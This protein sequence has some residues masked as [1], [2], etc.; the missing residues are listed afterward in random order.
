MVLLVLC[1][2]NLGHFSQ[3]SYFVDE[4]RSAFI[5]FASM[6][7]SSNSKVLSSLLTALRPVARLLMKA[8]IGYREF[9]EIAKCA[10]VDVAT[11]DYGLRGRPTNIS[12]VAVMT[13]L[14]RK[15][16]KRLR[17]KISSGI[18]AE[19]LRVI[20]PAEILERWHSDQEYLDS[21]GRP[22][23]LSFDGQPP[24]F[25]EL[26][27]KYGGDIP[28]GAMRTELKRVGAVTESDDG[29]LTVTKRYFRPV[30]QDEQLQRAFGQP[31][32]ALVKNIDH[33]IGH[34]ANEAW[35]ERLAYSTKIRC[36]DATRVRRIS[37]DRAAEFVEA[38]EDLF[39]AYETI[40]SDEDGEERPGVVGVGV[41]YFEDSRENSPFVG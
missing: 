30:E 9:S 23:S 16:V 29:D 33:N 12:R 21:S 35:V 8:G 13:G 28:P 38:I 5:Y 15:E 6:S 1:T 17:E 19:P 10:F 4:Y 25:T 36:G 41:Y 3:L 20:P 11:K 2:R 22:L 18:H 37:Q 7:N 27:K 40:Y 34:P 24:T 26:V 39:S 14:T 32:Y 31:I